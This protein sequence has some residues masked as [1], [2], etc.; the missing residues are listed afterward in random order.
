MSKMGSLDSRVITHGSP[1]QGRLLIRVKLR[2]AAR[3]SDSTT[4]VAIDK[5][6]GL[7]DFM[8]NL[9]DQSLTEAGV[10]SDPNGALPSGWLQQ[11]L[12]WLIANLPQIIAIILALFGGM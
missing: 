4:A 6:L 10:H 12:G 3:S 2:E 8:D 1:L 11:L 5:A 9:T 7:Q